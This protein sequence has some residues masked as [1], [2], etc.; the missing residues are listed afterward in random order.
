MKLDLNSKVGQAVVKFFDGKSYMIIDPRGMLKVHLKKFLAPFRMKAIE[1]SHHDKIEDLKAQIRREK[2]DLI[3]CF[4]E[5][6]EQSFVELLT[7][8]TS[9]QTDRLASSFFV[10][11]EDV[12]KVIAPE[13]RVLP[14]D[15]FILS[16]FSIQRIEDAVLPVLKAKASPKPERKAI[17]QAAI[18]FYERDFESAFEKFNILLTKIPKSKVLLNFLG[19]TCDEL[20]DL[21]GAIGYYKMASN[22]DPNYFQAVYNG[23]NCA[24]AEDEFQQAYHFANIIKDNHSLNPEFLEPLIQASLASRNFEDIFEYEEIFA[25]F[26]REQEVSNFVTNFMVNSLLSCAHVFHERHEDDQRDDALRRAA[27]WCQMNLDQFKDICLLHIESKN[28]NEIEKILEKVAKH[29]FESLLGEIFIFEIETLYK[30]TDYILS[31]GLKNIKQGIKS[32]LIYE[33][34]IKAHIEAARRRDIIE[35][36][37]YDAAKDFPDRSEFFHI[38]LTI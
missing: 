3:F 4:N 20:G 5:V 8:H 37:V 25:K 6:H 17:Y 9:I 15:G 18:D 29:N 36:L 23:L 28:I 22:L 21:N 35:D 1:V 24:V 10:I 14:V 32:E 30:D 2:P 26:K 7:L 34:V 19:M 38:F 31:E 16:P 13:V 12:K 33:N 27:H 11:A